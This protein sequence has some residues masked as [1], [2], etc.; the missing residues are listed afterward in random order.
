MDEVFVNLPLQSAQLDDLV[1]QLNE[2]GI[3]VHI[4][5]AD[6]LMV[7]TQRQFV[8]RLGGYT[9]LTTSINTIS[10][11][12]LLVKRLI[13]IIGGLVGCVLTG[14]LFL[15]LLPPLR[16]SHPDRYSF[17]RSVWEKRKEV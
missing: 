9:V 15:F 1:R 5:L 6:K 4:Q 13:D 7:G 11:G 12:E 2:M 16:F 8:E 14:I 3:T 17:P 10:T